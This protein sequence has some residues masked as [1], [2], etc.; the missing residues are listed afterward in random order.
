MSADVRGGTQ[1]S[2]HDSQAGKDHYFDDG[3]TGP[4]WPR[5]LSVFLREHRP[6]GGAA[7]VEDVVS[8]EQSGPADAGSDGRVET[9]VEAKALRE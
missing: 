6:S 9:I 3:S 5:Y 7:G 2:D 4:A 8:W 1:E